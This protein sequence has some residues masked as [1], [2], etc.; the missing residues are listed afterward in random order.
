L[1]DPA[2]AEEGYRMGQASVPAVSTFVAKQQTR[3][4]FCLTY[5]KPIEARQKVDGKDSLML[6]TKAIV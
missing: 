2:D 4:R 1:S 6:S 3:Q 5:R